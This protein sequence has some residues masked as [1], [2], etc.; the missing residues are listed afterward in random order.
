MRRRS[1]KSTKASAKSTWMRSTSTVISWKP[2][3]WSSWPQSAKRAAGEQ[4]GD[5]PPVR[6][7]SAAA[8]AY[9]SSPSVPAPSS[10]PTKTPSGFRTRRTSLKARGR[11]LTQLRFSELSTT[12]KAPSSKGRRASSSATTQETAS[13]T[14][15]GS[16]AHAA[17]SAGDRSVWDKREI[18]AAQA[19]STPASSSSARRS[20]SASVLRATS[21][22]RPT[23]RSATASRR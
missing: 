18:P 14:S 16:A 7:S 8:K 22:R 17:T 13:R 19:P 9:W 23:T 11:S 4:C 3:R 15:P 20:A 5:T 10:A 6:S 12:S 21:R 1:S 2:A